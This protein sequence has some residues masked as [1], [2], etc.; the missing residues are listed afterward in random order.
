VCLV[1]VLPVR[2][3]FRVPVYRRYR[4]VRNDPQR[5]PELPHKIPPQSTPSQCISGHS[6]EVGRGSRDQCMNSN[7]PRSRACD[8]AAGRVRCWQQVWTRLLQ[9]RI[10][11]GGGSKE[12]GSAITNK[13]EESYIARDRVRR[14]R[15]GSAQTSESRGLSSTACAATK[16]WAEWK[17]R[18]GGRDAVTAG[19]E[20][21]ATA[22]KAGG[23]QWAESESAATS[24]WGD[25]LSMDQSDAPGNGHDTQT[26]AA[27]QCGPYSQITPVTRSPAHSS[28]RTPVLHSLP[29][30][31]SSA[32]RHSNA[33]LRAWGHH[34]VRPVPKKAS[35]AHKSPRAPRRPPRPTRARVPP[36]KYY[37]KAPPWPF[38]STASR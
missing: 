7:G 36:A 20:P 6:R 15:V 8:W 23:P 4:P 27:H 5:S 38:N 31:Q 13:Q 17:A 26:K 2:G 24:D 9:V 1:L 25:E 37:S 21:W 3:I 28:G 10:R 33:P 18:E 16:G 34:S 14:S 11:N 22:P 29:F 32:V 12:Q 30:K 35:G 19:E